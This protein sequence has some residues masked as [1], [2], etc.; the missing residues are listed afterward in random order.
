[1]GIII[2]TSTIFGKSRM[3]RR[4]TRS[5]PNST[6]QVL[7]QP[8]EACQD[9]L[10]FRFAFSEYLKSSAESVSEPCFFTL[11]GRHRWGLSLHLGITTRQYS[12]M[13]IARG[14]VN[15]S[16]KPVKPTSYLTGDLEF[17]AM[18]LGREGYASWWCMYCMHYKP[19]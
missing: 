10:R 18:V 17:L 5:C 15:T 8:T 14:L 13:L 1:V 16:I 4:S 6:I 9:M 19:E 12:A 7:R 2:H 11:R 3:T